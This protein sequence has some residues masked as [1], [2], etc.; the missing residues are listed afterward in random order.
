MQY[1]EKK[2]LLFFISLSEKLPIRKEKF[3]MRTRRVGFDPSE[4]QRERE[5]LLRNVIYIPDSLGI[6][7]VIPLDGNAEGRYSASDK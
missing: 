6:G 1:K 7:V 3:Q 4:P 2:P 5:R